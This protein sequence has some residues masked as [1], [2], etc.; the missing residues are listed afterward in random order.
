MPDTDTKT[1]TEQTLDASL[2]TQKED[3][4]N[5]YKV[6]LGDKIMAE[7]AQTL[8][9]EGTHKFLELHAAFDSLIEKY[10]EM[11]VV[12]MIPVDQVGEYNSF[13]EYLGFLR[14]LN[15]KISAMANSAANRKNK[16]NAVNQVSTALNNML[17]L[18]GTTGDIATAA[19][20]S[21]EFCDLVFKPLIKLPLDIKSR[22]SLP[23]AYPNYDEIARYVH[24]RAEQAEFNVWLLAKINS[25]VKSGLEKLTAQKNIMEETRDDLE[26]RDYLVE[27]QKYLMENGWIGYAKNEVR[28][29]AAATKEI[30]RA[31]YSTDLNI[32]K[33]KQAL[34][35]DIIALK[36]HAFLYLGTTLTAELRKA[37]Y[38]LAD[39]VNKNYNI[40]GKQAGMDV[41]MAASAV[42]VQ[43][44]ARQ[45]L[46]KLLKV[47]NDIEFA[48]EAAKTK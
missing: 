20:S 13:T 37:I 48:G 19:A 18:V 12:N 41:L 31:G 9:E 33:G 45:W 23:K 34:Q 21:A 40:E 44:F 25:V 36:S 27:L 35:L 39:S 26:P 2:A 32:A 8:G 10:P 14:K 42:Y 15:T 7:M 5:Q 3:R 38:R 1:L 24:S 29:A 46:V 16:D 47:F 6:L 30:T 22:K 11:D 28:E 43:D 17:A 4:I